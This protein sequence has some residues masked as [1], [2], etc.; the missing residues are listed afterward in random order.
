LTIALLAGAAGPRTPFRDP[1]ALR[2]GDCFTLTGD[3]TGPAQQ[4]PVVPCTRAHN[5]EVFAI[6]DVGE[7]VGIMPDEA[8]LTKAVLAACRPALDSYVLDPLVVPAS[9]GMGYYYD[10]FM[11]GGRPVTC[12]VRT[13]TAISHSIRT[14]RSTLTPAQLLFLTTVK[15]VH[16]LVEQVLGEDGT[17]AWE[18]RRDAAGQLAAAVSTEDQALGT[19]DWPAAAR[20]ALAR[21][22]TAQEPGIPLWRQAGAALLEPAFQAL[23]EQAER[24]FDVAAELPVR[25]ALGLPTSQGGPLRQV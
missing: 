8:S 21:L 10:Q 14:D 6:V 5:A 7:N 1:V 20:A 11:G 19:G 24:Y 12:L 25:A 18:L 9:T 15:P 3:L 2:V 13:P 23:L 16:D 4:V 17:Q 22:V